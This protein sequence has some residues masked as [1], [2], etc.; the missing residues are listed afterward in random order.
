[1]RTVSSTRRP[2]LI[3]S[4]FTVLLA[5][6]AA[7]ASA[8]PNTF[9]A[10]VQKH[11]AAWDADHNGTLSPDEVD[12]L[13]VDPSWKGDDAAAI[14]TLKI[15][16][17]SKKEPLAS[18]T[19]ADLEKAAAKPLAEEPDAVPT[20]PGVVKK[21]ATLQARFAVSSR[22]IRSV[23]RDL[24][25][26]PTPDL[27]K[28]HQGRIGDCFFVS[29]VGAMVERDPESVKKM[30]VPDDKNGYTVTFGTKK[31]VT[32]EPFTDV[33]FA[34]V[35]TT[36][37]E[38]LWLPVLEK[39]FGELRNDS[40]PEDKRTQ[41][42][43]DAI[44][45][46]GDIGGS[47]VVL[48]GHRAERVGLRPDKNPAAKNQEAFLETLRTKIGAAVKAKKLVGAGTDDKPN[49]PGINP[50]H[51]YAI[52]D[53]DS[54]TDTL[55]MWNPH[56]NT[57]RPKAAP[58]LTAGYPTKGGRFEMPLKDF[59][60]TFRGLCIETDEPFDTPT[61]TPRKAATGTK[62]PASKT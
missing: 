38:G 3:A 43:T 23:K 2:A 41:S 22:A 17:R 46:G 15:A 18:L 25:A 12:K 59:A 54:R 62:K 51:A 29:M 13:T 61:S 37:D 8:Y 14:A 55:K 1:M 5:G 32:V 36:G 40:K 27:D 49:V 11:F 44:A 30:I 28:F 34:L 20:Q 48:T 35:S 21:P 31:T 50:N 6:V 58:G 10:V 60:A 19:L 26:D 33:E 45:R 9:A 52:F 56:G 39:A 42:V 57:F 53:Y 16:M 47:I 7:P 4:L 24:F